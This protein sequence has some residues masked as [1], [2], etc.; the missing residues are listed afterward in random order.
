MTS[1][2]IGMTSTASAPD[3]ARITG[4]PP[5]RPSGPGSREPAPQVD[6]VSEVTRRA[7]NGPAVIVDF[8]QLRRA[9]ERTKAQ[10]ASPG[11]LSKEEQRVVAELK[12]RDR[13][14]RA[15]EQA[16]ASA[17]GAYAGTP[18]YATER[19]PD[20][21]QYAVAGST[22]IDVTPIPGD[23]NATLR[24]MEI[25]KRAAL[26]RRI[27]RPRTAPSPPAPRPRA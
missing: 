25:V 19:G 5:L 9:D 11:A 4:T 23:P 10:T 7:E 18:S 16:H 14:V 1:A 8:R 3:F 21:G 6:G 26:G 20:G 15:H 17:G 2:P 12:A 27:R 22:P 13:E 24:K